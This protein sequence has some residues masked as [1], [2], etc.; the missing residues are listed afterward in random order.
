MTNSPAPGQRVPLLLLLVATVGLTYEA[1]LLFTSFLAPYRFPIPY[2]VPVFDT[3]FVLVATGIGYLCLERHRIRQDFQSAA[4]GISLWLAALMAVAHILTQPDYPRSPGVNPGVAPYFFFAS[5]LAAIIGVGLG[6]HY[7]DRQLPLTDRRRW[8]IGAGSVAVSIV[9]ALLVLIVCPLLPPLVM[10]PGR[11]TPFAVWIAGVINGVAAVWAL[12]SWRRRLSTTGSQHGFVNLLALAAFIWVLGLIGFLLFPYRYAISGYLAGAAR[13][14]GVGVIFVAL[15]REQAWLYRE[16]R[17]RLRDLEQLHQAGQALV[18]SRDASDIVHTIAAKGLAITQA[19]A[20][21]L[22]RLDA[23]ARVLRAVTCSGPAGLRIDD[24]ELPIG[25]GPS[26]LAALEQRPVWTSN[27]HAD[28]LLHL[29]GDVGAR[30]ARQGLTAALAVPLLTQGGEVFGSLSIFFRESRMFAKADVELL[31]A[32][33]TQASAALENAGAFDRLALQ[34]MHDAAL[35][36]FGRHLLEATTEK[37]ILDDAIDTTARLL[38]ADTVALFLAD[39]SGHLR[40]AAARSEW[41]PDTA[42]TDDGSL[43]AL[44]EHAL[45]RRETI[46]VE[47][48][49]LE[50]RFSIPGYF[51]KHGIHSAIMMRLRVQEQPLGVLASYNRAPRRF[52]LE[53]KRIFTSLAHQIAVALDKVRLYAELRNNLQRLQETQ[54]QLIQADKL[55]ALGT[56]LSGMAHELNNPLSTIHLSVE[57]LK[58]KASLDAPLARRVEIIGTACAR[59]SRIV[60]DLLVFA[61]RKTPERQWVNLGEVIELTLNLQIPQLELNKIQTVTALEPTPAIWAD[62]HQLQ[63]VFLNLF[64]NAIHAMNTA[65]GHGVLTV[66]SMRRGTEVVVE[67]E[68]DGPGIPPEHLGRIFDP[69]F[70]TKAAGSGTGLGLSLAIGIVDAHGGRMHAENLPRAGARFTMY[71]PVGEGAE[72][73]LPAAPARPLPAVST[74]DILVIEDEDSL[75][76]LL[77]EVIHGL[78]HQVAEATTGQEALAL[79]QDR[80]YDLVILDLRLPDVDGQVVWQRAIAS[81]PRLAGRVVFMTGDIMSADTQSFLDDTGRPFLI[82]PFTMEQ[83]GRVVSEVLVGPGH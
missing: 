83:V 64:S 30:L 5:Y 61:R 46:E 82:K 81:D 60:S 7:A 39:S 10:P 79:L 9:I 4:I 20:S 54:A 43:A 33:G 67:V 26:G 6:T 45:A 73:V 44:A 71:L 22:F 50:Q 47:D 49:R 74:A 77:T 76:G 2:A 32:F 3:P 16:A 68:D 66:R 15:L 38:H 17:A 24:L 53:D 27:V 18:A 21:I 72:T 36:E 29:P 48:S 41:R 14:L 35:Q 52:T 80:P 63:Q 70:T 51:E 34:A 37:D 8:M 19:D 65:H 1:L 57:L 23:R 75:R 13:P 58:R 28:P 25:R 42:G 31:S 59:A 11:L 55:K 62:S 69:F 12:G 56:M 40:W 78:G